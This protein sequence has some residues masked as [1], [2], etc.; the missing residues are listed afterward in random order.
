MRYF[1]N[2]VIGNTDGSFCIRADKIV[3]VKIKLVYRP[4]RSWVVEVALDG[5]EYD[6]EWEEF[7]IGIDSEHN[8]KW[9]VEQIAKAMA[10]GAIEAQDDRVAA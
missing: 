3:A 7:E 6:P 9:T 5:G 4:T 8:A 10:G 1:G 2:N